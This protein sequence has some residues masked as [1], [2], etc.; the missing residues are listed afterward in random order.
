MK[1]FDL[2]LI[3]TGGRGFFSFRRYSI[4]FSR[5]KKFY[6]LAYFYQLT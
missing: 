1:S 2:R 6:T 3:L 4:N 5:P